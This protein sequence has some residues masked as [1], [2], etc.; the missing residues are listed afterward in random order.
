[1]SPDSFISIIISTRDKDIKILEKTLL[2][3]LSSDISSYEV[4]IVDQ[5]PN[6]DAHN[7]AKRLERDHPAKEL[8]CVKTDR[9]GLS[10]GRNLGF[11]K[12]KGNWILFFDDD[13]ILPKNFLKK[14]E[15]SLDGEKNKPVVFY[16]KV[17]NVEDKSY[18]IKRAIRTPFLS[19]FNFDT[20]CSIGLLF[21]RRVIKEIGNFDINFGV[22]SRFGAGEEADLIIRALKKGYKIKYLKDF[23]VYHPKAEVDL[24]QKYSYGYGLGALYKKHIF[25]SGQCFLILGGKFLGELVMRV[26]LC[27]LFLFVDFQKTNLH[28]NYL[29]GFI[30]GFLSY[31][32]VYQRKKHTELTQTGRF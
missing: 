15:K 11:A 22:G 27:T 26:M 9:Q 16:G 20:A 12:S 28:F 23:K 7:L 17:L 31:S 10:E 8:L 29:K 13:A 4:I 6:L 2:S 5:N 14:I 18:Y 24:P 1:M 32:P 30:N 25:G 21:N 19:L 3:I